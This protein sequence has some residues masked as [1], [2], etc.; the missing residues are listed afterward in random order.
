[1]ENYRLGV[2]ED[3]VGWK[4]W[5][6]LLNQADEFETFQDI[7]SPKLLRYQQQNLDPIGSEIHLNLNEF[8]RFLVNLTKEEKQYI[9][10]KTYKSYENKTITPNSYSLNI[11]SG[12]L[13]N[14]FDLTLHVGYDMIPLTFDHAYYQCFYHAKQVMSKPHHNDNRF[15]VIK[16]LF[17]WV[18]S[19]EKQKEDTF[20]KSV[21]KFSFLNDAEKAELTDVFHR[22]NEIAISEHHSH[23]F[24]NDIHYLVKPNLKIE[25]QLFLILWEFFPDTVWHIQD[26]FRLTIHK[27]LVNNVLPQIHNLFHELGVSI[28]WEEK[29][30][31]NI[32]LSFDLQI[33]K[34][35][36]WFELH[37]NIFPM[38]E[39]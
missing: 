38:I 18:D 32:S 8:N 39:H 6:Q 7:V 28:S 23:V 34:T 30:I 1:M 4:P 36:D 33:K 37:P 15:N 9:S 29:P 14:S 19:D 24:H 13:V 31:E 17:G 11:H 35:N 26:E 10:L 22:L 3:T 20:I 27:R 12:K 21:E 16:L 5:D 2:V 25:G